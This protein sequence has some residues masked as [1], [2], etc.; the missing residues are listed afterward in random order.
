[1]WYIRSLIEGIGYLLLA[2]IVIPIAIFIYG[3]LLTLAL[4]LADVI[5]ICWLGHPV[6]FPFIHRVLG[7]GP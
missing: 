7:V 2:C 5:V 6:I 3:G 1:M 4:V